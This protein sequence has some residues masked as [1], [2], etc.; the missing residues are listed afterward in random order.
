MDTVRDVVAKEP[1]I[2]PRES[3]DCH[4]TEWYAQGKSR[5]VAIDGVRVTIR[6][7]GRHGRRARIAITASLGT[8]FYAADVE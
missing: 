5:V 1:R 7:V 6:L 3:R 4:S 8:V 2:D